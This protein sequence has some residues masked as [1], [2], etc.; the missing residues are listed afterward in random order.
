MVW[1]GHKLQYFE[2][3]LVSVNAEHNSVLRRN[4]LDHD[5]HDQGWIHK[6]RLYNHQDH[7]HCALLRRVHLPFVFN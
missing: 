2:S 7:L 3:N 1:A 6:V 5:T 4:I